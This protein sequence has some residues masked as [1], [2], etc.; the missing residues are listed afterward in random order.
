[1]Q[2]H[3]QIPA[4]DQG[5]ED[6][7][8][9]TSQQQLI[10]R[11]DRQP[12]T[13]PDQGYQIE[14]TEAHGPVPVESAFP[15]SDSEV[16][17]TEF[18]RHYLDGT[19]PLN[20]VSDAR[21]TIANAAPG[22]I[23][24]FGIPESRYNAAVEAGSIPAG[25]FDASSEVAHTEPGASELGALLTQDEK[26]ETVK[27]GY[28]REF[29]PVQRYYIDD[30]KGVR[31]ADTHDAR[32]TLKILSEAYD[33]IDGDK[34]IR[35]L[36]LSPTKMTAEQLR[37]TTNVMR[38]IS[39][40]SAGGVFDRLHTVTI[41]PEDNP[42]LQQELKLPDGSKVSLPLN[43]YRDLGYLTLSDRLLKPVD[44]RPPLPIDTA[45]FFDTRLLPGEPTEGPDKPRKKVSDNEW[46]LTFA[47]EVTH[48]GITEEAQKRVPLPGIA[49]TLY[50]RYN[51]DEH[52]AELGAAE[53]AGGD[54][55]LAVPQD[56]R[57]ALS[58]MWQYEKGSKDGGLTYGRALGPHYVACR[59]LDISQ[60]LPMRPRN[61]QQALTTSI[62]YQLVPEA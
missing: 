10:E 19:L 38:S 43:G 39:D 34:T 45:E 37:Q 33:L 7:V 17:A 49:P 31:T 23:A 27:M 56:Q 53:Y 30:L 52:I 24:R 21:R 3:E 47:H 2:I 15:A 13:M 61:S 54:V 1:M 59:E 8:L 44:E 55:A 11:G 58:A 36:N 9:D 20:I 42:C 29:R 28:Y 46:E 50:G 35:L 60:P 12:P 6:T 5:A 57:E 32:N 41:L 62:I 14:R 25:L 4:T 48:M 51:A 26:E 22:F 40:K 18:A 16:R